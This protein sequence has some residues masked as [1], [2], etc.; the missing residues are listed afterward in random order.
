M[1]NL[2]CVCAGSA[3]S[4]GRTLKQASMRRVC[5]SIKPNVI[6]LQKTL[7]DEVKARHLYLFCK[8]NICIYFSKIIFVF[9]MRCIDRNEEKKEYAYSI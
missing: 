6:F 9:T 4:S 2:H 5:R 1:T 7:V 3:S 8:N